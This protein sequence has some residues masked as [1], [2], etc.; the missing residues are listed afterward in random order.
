MLM[1]DEGKNRFNLRVIGVWIHEGHV[2]LHQGIHDDY[3]SL[4]GGRGE[5]M[6]LSEETVK[7]EFLEELGVEVTV[8]RLLYFMENFYHFEELDR[9]FHEVSFYYKVSTEAPVE[10]LAKDRV[11]NCIEEGSDLIYK[12]FP[13]TELEQVNLYPV[14]LR[15]GLQ[16]LPTGIQHVVYNEFATDEPEFSM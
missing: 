14:F 15:K 11:Y 13:L 2:L 12:W 4:P 6:E 9:V 16:Q 1:F 7:R 5:L 10:M 3:W 8:G